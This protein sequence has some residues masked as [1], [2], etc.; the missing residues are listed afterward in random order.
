MYFYIPVLV[1]WRDINSQSGDFAAG[2]ERDEVT[3]TLLAHYLCNFKTCFLKVNSPV[4]LSDGCS[5]L[6]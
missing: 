4:C 2:T 1:V 5:I 6:T 3:C